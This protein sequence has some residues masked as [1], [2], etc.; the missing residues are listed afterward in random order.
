MTNIIE[1]SLLIGFGILILTIF[2]SI[3]SPFLGKII[4]FNKNEKKE[5]ETYTNLINEI[6][7]G[8]IYVIQNP[9]E[10]YL[11]KIEYP[12]NLNISFY[13]RFAEY[14]FILHNTISKNVI[15]Y[16]QTFLRSHFYELPP[17]TYLLNISETSSLIRIRITYIY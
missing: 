14:E 1:K 13:G 11:K 8:I 4:E 5:L 7:F 17:Q 3:I 16:N 10:C 2:S 12:S 9:N 15:I 6:D